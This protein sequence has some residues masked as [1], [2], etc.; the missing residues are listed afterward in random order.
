MIS[1][2]SQSRKHKYWTIPRTQ[3]KHA[4]AKSQIGDLQG[5]G[6]GEMGRYLID[7]EF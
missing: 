2:T 7:V 3:D 6:R 1:E 4:L 5:Q